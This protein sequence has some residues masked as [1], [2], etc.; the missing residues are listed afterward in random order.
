MTSRRPTNNPGPGGPSEGGRPLRLRRPPPARAVWGIALAWPSRLAR[1]PRRVGCA[2]AL[3]VGRARRGRVVRPHADNRHR[4]SRPGRRRLPRRSPGP[5]AIE[6][7]L[8]A[9]ISGWPS[10]PAHPLGAGLAVWALQVPGGDGKRDRAAALAACRLGAGHVEHPAAV[11]TDDC[12]RSAV[13]RWRSGRTRR[14]SVPQ[15]QL[16][17][18]ACC[19]GLAA[20][21]GRSSRRHRRFPALVAIPG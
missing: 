18:P 11:V 15:Y 7:H 6:R 17:A 16:V 10:G 8:V 5:G 21:G 13:G 20:R 2:R 9:V 14:S 19:T 12:F 3:R 4:V 1:S